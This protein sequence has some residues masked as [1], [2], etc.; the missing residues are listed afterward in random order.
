MAPLL[1]A[2]ETATDRSSVALLRGDALVAEVRAPRDRPAAASLLPA[3]EAVL[4]R[5]G[6]R[7]AELD[8]FAISIGPGSFTGLR[9]GLATVKGLAFGSGRPVVPVSTLA[10]IA[11]GSGVSDQ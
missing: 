4:A 9:V 7:A 5:A 6:C 1:L 8:A 10:A 2:I 3:L 11:C